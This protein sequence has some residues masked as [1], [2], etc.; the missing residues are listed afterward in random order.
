MFCSECG[1]AIK[2]DLNFC[3]R[4]G[5]EVSGRV[6]GSGE[7]AGNLSNV[8]GAIGVFGFLG[9]L[10]VLYLLLSNGIPWPGVTWIS[11]F[12]L[13][14]LVIICSRILRIIAAQTGKSAGYRPRTRAPDELGVPLN[15]QLI[16]DRGTPISVV[17]H[18]TR[19]LDKVPVSGE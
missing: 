7:V 13:A 15:G 16:A 2:P 3:S 17:E 14:T 8:V 9:Y 10:A 19:T 11:L 18:T 1:S 5:A 6:S 4:C 12:Y